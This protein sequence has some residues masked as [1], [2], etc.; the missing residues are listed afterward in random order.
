MSKHYF[1]RLGAGATSV[2]FAASLLFP[3]AAT[4]AAPFLP[5]LPAGFT[6]APGV[7]SNLD[8]NILGDAFKAKLAGALIP[9]NYVPRTDSDSPIK[10]IVELRSEPA[11]VA[12]QSEGASF[13]PSLQRN[14]LR[15]EHSVFR[16]AASRLGAQTGSEFMEVFNGY[17]VTLPGNK[18][19]LLLE[20]P[21]VKAVYP[22]VTVHAAPVA[23][24][25]MAAPA[26]PVIASGD[27][28]GTDALT[29]KGI[30]GEGIQVAVLDTGIDYNHPF[31][32]DRYAGG[33]DF[34]D[35]DSD[36]YETD[37]PRNLPADKDGHPYETSHGTHVSGIIAGVAPGAELY[38]YR[39]LGPYGDGTTEQFMAGIERAVA[40]GADVINMSLGSSFNQAYAPDAI[41]A[42]NAVKAGVTVIIA[43]GNNGDRGSYTLT[44][45]GG[46]HRAITVGAST[47]P[48]VSPMIQIGD[49]EPIYG[50]LASMSP[51]LTDDALDV[52]VV[53]AGIGS[54]DDFAKVDVKGAIALV[55]RGGLDFSAKSSNAKAAGAAALLIANN[56][57]EPIRPSLSRSG[58]YVPTYGIT[59]EEGQVLKQQLRGGI[60]VL[61]YQLVEE[62]ARLASF[63]SRGPGMPDHTIKPDII[64]PGVDI[65]SSVP[66]WGSMDGTYD[67]AYAE[68]Q[69]TSMAA[70]HIAGASALLLQAGEDLLHTPFDP[71]Q[72]KSL[73]MNSAE[74]LTDREGYEYGYF[75]QG[76]GLPHLERVIQ[77]NAVAKVY[78]L[79]DIG[80]PGLDPDPY[81]TGSLSYGLQTRNTTVTKTV[82]LDNLSGAP[83]D[84]QVEIEW[85]TRHAGINAAAGVTDIN[86]PAEGAS[87]D[88][89]LSVAE[90]A[91]DGAY[92][93]AV[94]L[95]GNGGQPL[96]LPLA[97][98]VGDDLKP[99]PVSDLLLGDQIFSPNGDGIYDTDRLFFSVNEK[100]TSLHLEVA[101]YDFSNG[102]GTVV[103]DLYA[104]GDAFG[105]G[106]YEVD[107]DGS[108]YDPETGR[109]VQLDDGFYIVTPVYG[110]EATRLDNQAYSFAVD[111]GAPVVSSVLLEELAPEDGQ[112]QAVLYGDIL[113]DL[114]TGLIDGTGAYQPK[115]LFG[116]SA[117]YRDAD[118]S[119]RQADGTLSSNGYFEIAVPLKEGMN[120]FYIYAYDIAGNGAADED[121]VQLLRYS[122]DADAVTVTPTLSAANVEIGQPVTVDVRFS[123]SQSV[124]GAMLN[125]AY[126]SRLQP[127]VIESS[128]QLATYQEEHYPGVPLAEYSNTFGITD[129]RQVQQYGVHL[130]GGA[131]SGTGSVARFTFVP[132]EAGSYT[133]ELGDI[134]IWNE[135]RTFTAAEGLA[136]AH[137]TVTKPTTGQPGQPGQ[138]GQQG[139][140]PAATPY[141]SGTLTAS[142][143]G[144]AKLPSAVLAVSDAAVN[145]SL[146]QPQASNAIIPL[147]DV[148]FTQYSTVRVSLSP[149]QADKFKQSGKGLQLQGEVFSLTIPADTLTD[150]ISAAGL[151]VELT[152]QADTGSLSLNG[153]TTSLK[154]SV[155]TV[156]NGWTSG[157]PVSLRLLLN[158]DA[159]DIRKIGAYHER[160]DGAWTYLQF[161]TL[162]ANGSLELTLSEDGT[163]AAAAGAG[164]FR[165]LTGHWAKDEIEILA[166]HRLVAG[167]G[168][169]GGFIPSDAVNHAE[170]LTMLDRLQGKGDTWMT[171]IRKQEARKP[172]TRQEA[173]ILVAETL[174]ADF[175]GMT[176]AL[177]F[178][179]SGKIAPEAR[180]AVAF[181][182]SQGYMKGEGIHFNPSGT[183]TRA[184]TAVL[185]YRILQDLRTP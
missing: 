163:Y 33:Y 159:G 87:F 91:G 135:G 52:K 110:D 43:A 74:P 167:K 98:F 185:L 76:A 97:V 94:K 8:G 118:G 21:G 75:E 130:T 177:P 25:D 114:L 184:Q 84:Y 175:T 100:L 20:I 49:A 138:Q 31:L 92:E 161:G 146:N 6:E 126:D 171:H 70:P 122:N 157:K 95:T 143:A 26:V 28:I 103:G 34:I 59:L 176:G 111:T 14:V 19:N 162:P 86:L 66:V 178:A 47:K 55:D 180:Q 164:T 54:A 71:E 13:S 145:E 18:V 112:R 108:V 68:E 115:D 83:Q 38:V 117:V 155:V 12:E 81:F 132:T 9:K 64:A 45:P 105:K 170:L 109:Q 174:D 101:R 24:A 168:T 152:L 106:A 160:T 107:W 11:K 133:F 35:N 2:C 166:A 141:R 73:L 165:D 88:V 93:G 53:Y 82:Y 50:E 27:L 57:A 15:S 150:W 136:K 116:I 99:D 85:Y 40:D 46:S 144:A 67:T 80:T 183:L 142:S 39:V 154:S 139:N 181:M 113:E 58:D 151:N 149:G 90:A 42:D 29:G 72:I 32:E 131:Y 134:L 30:T 96:I 61:S 3:G 10:V 120:D 125:M 56:E 51:A 182:L 140:Q 89:S 129:G 78:E 23:A 4:A 124:Y 1:R 137:L 77:N 128:V 63:S 36:P 153:S 69:G 148:P 119:I 79:L 62:P 173:A 102:A 172:L 121:Y 156:K 127:P 22:D 169:N 5:P 123:A 147:T 104:H 179:D 44:T 65:L 60:G 17:A 37:N 16:Q 48:V 41:A 158:A 7:T